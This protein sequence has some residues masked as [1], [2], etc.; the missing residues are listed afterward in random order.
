MSTK[1]QNSLQLASWQIGFGLILL[2][3]WGPSVQSL[4]VPLGTPTTL[5]P[6]HAAEICMFGKSVIL[7]WPWM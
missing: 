1:R 3:R 6:P 7:N 2:H 4:H 5:G